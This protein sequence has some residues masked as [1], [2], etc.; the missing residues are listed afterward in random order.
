[1]IVQNLTLVVISNLTLVVILNINPAFVSTL[2]PIFV[3]SLNV[4]FVSTLTTVVLLKLSPVVIST[5]TLVS[6]R[7]LFLSENVLLRCCHIESHFCF[8]NYTYSG[9]RKDFHS[10]CHADSLSGCR[11]DSYSGSCSPC[12][13]S[14][15]SDFY[16]DCFS[17]SSSGCPI[18]SYFC[19]HIDSYSGCLIDRY[20]FGFNIIP[21]IRLLHENISLESRIKISSCFM[22]LYIGCHIDLSCFSYLSMSACML[23]SLSFHNIFS[24]IFLPC[25]PG[26]LI[27]LIRLYTVLLRLSCKTLYVFISS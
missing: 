8:R 26:S 13:Y 16:S 15:R 14:C 4:I 2:T 7:L 11:T 23:H 9:C 3:L 6:Y 21:S 20:P 1:M 24:R 22:P 17:L 25:F 5:L 10:G 27:E 18:E 12:Y 19:C